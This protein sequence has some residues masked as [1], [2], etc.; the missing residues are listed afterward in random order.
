MPQNRKIYQ[1]NFTNQNWKLSNVQLWPKWNNGNGTYKKLLNSKLCRNFLVLYQTLAKSFK[2]MQYAIHR[3]CF[4]LNEVHWIS[5][6]MLN[7]PLLEM[8]SVKMQTNVSKN[9]SATPLLW[10]PCLSVLATVVLSQ[11]TISMKIWRTVILK[12]LLLHTPIYTLTRVCIKQITML[13]YLT[14]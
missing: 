4:S 9:Y 6:W 10:Y 5:S 13:I 11:N 12:T 1:K 8:T 2:I 3:Y 14:K 7:T